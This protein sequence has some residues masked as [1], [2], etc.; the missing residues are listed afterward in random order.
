MPTTKEQEHNKLGVQV[1]TNIN[2][3]RELYD[4]YLDAVAEHIRVASELRAL[5]LRHVQEDYESATLMA[6]RATLSWAKREAGRLYMEARKAYED[7]RRAR[8]EMDQ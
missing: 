5:E 7:Y 3:E 1:M 8:V 2:R 6:E 4:R